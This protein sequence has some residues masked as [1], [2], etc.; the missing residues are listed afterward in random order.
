[1]PKNVPQ[2]HVQADN[3]G[4]IYGCDITE[5]KGQQHLIVVDYKSVCI[6]KCWLN[7]LQSNTV[8]DALEFI[9]CDIGAPDKLISNNARYFVSEEFIMNWNIIHVTSS[10]RYPQGNSHMEKA[11]Q[12]VKS[13]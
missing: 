4:K 8:I 10:L 7:N 3:P 6:F 12:I 5:I 13:I 9:F 2:F 1:M 11:V